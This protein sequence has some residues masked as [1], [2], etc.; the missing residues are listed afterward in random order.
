[1]RELEAV[2]RAVASERNV[3]VVGPA[4]IGKSALLRAASAHWPQP[5][6]GSCL[7]ALRWRSYLPVAQAIGRSL[8]AMD[9]AEAA[10]VTIDV[11]GGDVL[12]IDDLQWIDDE[13][14]AVLEMVTPRMRI[15]GAVRT[16]DSDSARALELAT[17][18]G[19]EVIELRPLEPT[20]VRELLMERFPHVDADRAADAVARCGGNPLLI[21]VAAGVPGLV[22]EHPTISTLIARLPTASRHNLAFLALAGEPVDP[23]WLD[24]PPDDLLAAELAV[25]TPQGLTVRHELFGE[26]ALRVLE[27]DVRLVLHE[28]LSRLAPSPA[29][30]ARH[31]VA[32]GRW[33]VAYENATDALDGPLTTSERARI[34]EL[35]AEAVIAIPDLSADPGGLVVSAAAAQI[36]VANFAGAVRL[37]A[38]VD[39]NWPHHRAGA[40]LVQADVAY[41]TGDPAR[42]RQLVESALALP[43]VADHRSE[44]G[45]RVLRSR[46]TARF[47]FDGPRALVLA[48]EALERAQHHGTLVAAATGLVGSSLLTLNDPDS[49]RWLA[50]G[51]RLAR[52]EGDLES[53]SMLADTLSAS[54]MLQGQVLAGIELADDMVARWSALGLA[55]RARDFAGGRAGS[56]ILGGIDLEA[57]VA[58]MAERRARRQFTRH[59]GNDLGALIAGLADLGRTA[60]AIDLAEEAVDD[61]TWDATNRSMHGWGLA[62]MWWLVGEPERAIAAAR[63]AVAASPPGF[64]SGAAAA[65]PWAWSE[66][67]LGRAITAPAPVPLFPLVA[68]TAIEH[69]ALVA[70]TDA[71]DEAADLFAEA[72]EG[73]IG[74]MQRNAVRARYGEALA[75]GQAGDRSR[76]AEALALATTMAAAMGFGGFQARLDRLRRVDDLGR[77]PDL[78][79]RA[80]VGSRP[81]AA[82]TALTPRERHVLEL[83]GRGLRTREIAAELKVAESTVESIVMASRRKLGARNRTEAV[84]LAEALRR[85]EPC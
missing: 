1:M 71:P 56:R 73:W 25:T 85:D 9:V 52:E 12:V 27:D 55:A 60:D 42:S 67:E 76:A 65:L 68:P 29:G 7:H 38:W 44:V 75:A 41:R 2:A 79:R 59:P 40:R 11:V 61:D 24:T 49:S 46:L 58:E 63:A 18:I 77:V 20:D 31:A 8:E 54:L 66:V 50:E 47:D 21:E 48:H 69:R 57:G 78:R 19:A 62:E 39:E 83:V 16:G 3:V 35:Q 81:S 82:R 43:D 51:I 53:E 23:A 45:L 36:P 37:A 74:R 15:V 14:A 80:G 22:S 13:S 84:R 26:A 17:K 64:P 32:I 28:R 5:R 4:G 30:R 34:L 33:T 72:S 70:L 10:N 6:W